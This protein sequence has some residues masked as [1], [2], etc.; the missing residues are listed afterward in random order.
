[1][2]PWDIKDAVTV[3]GEE[4]ER[5]EMRAHLVQ[6]GKFWRSHMV[7]HDPPGEWGIGMVIEWLCLLRIGPFAQYYDLLPRH[8][9]CPGCSAAG[10][11]GSPHSFTRASWPG[12]CLEECRDCGRKWLVD[13]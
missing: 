11:H 2:V 3:L 9:A 5:R 12:G 6:L 1:V 10:G 4:F 13:C 7:R 8:T